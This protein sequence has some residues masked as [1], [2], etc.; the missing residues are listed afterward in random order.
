MR[1]VAVADFLLRTPQEFLPRIHIYSGQQG[2]MGFGHPGKITY[3]HSATAM[4]F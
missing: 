4:L 2:E 3:C 1:F